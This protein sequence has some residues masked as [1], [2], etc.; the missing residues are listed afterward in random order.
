MMLDLHGY[1]LHV[2]WKEF[3]SHMTD[4]YHQKLKTTSVITG[5]GEI[6]K[7]LPVWADNNKHVRECVQSKRNPGMFI[8]NFSQSPIQPYT[9]NQSTKVDISPLI[10]KFNNK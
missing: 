10:E 6:A 2:A 9:Y 5:Q 1:T 4:C 3:S 7:E 8:I